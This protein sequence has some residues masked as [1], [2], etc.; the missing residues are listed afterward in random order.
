MF[1][2]SRHLLN[3]VLTLLLVNVFLFL[4]DLSIAQVRIVKGKVVDAQTHL[5]LASCSIY[6]LRSGKGV[7]SEEDGSYSLQISDRTDSIA[8]SRVGYVPVSKGVS[9]AAEQV[10]N[11]EIIPSQGGLHEVLITSKSKL[12]KAQRLIKKVIHYKDQN[13]S[14]NNKNIQSQVYDKIE[15]DVKNIPS[16]IQRNKLLKPLQFLFNNMDSSKEKN[17]FLPVYL[18]E[19]NS[20]FYYQKNPEK[21]RYDYLAIQG[22]GL[23]NSSMLTYIDGLYKK[24]NIYNNLIK[25]VD[26]NFVSPI[27]SNALA[28]YN[29]TIQDT[30]YIDDHRCIQ[31]QFSPAQYGSNTFNGF[32]WI[33]DTT[34]AIKSMV[35]HMDKKANINWVNKFQITQEFELRDQKYLPEKNILLI[36]LSIP[37]MK[38]TGIIATKTTLFRNII[39]NDLKIDTAF[40]K[41]TQDLTTLPVTNKDTTYWALHRFEPL[42]K[43]EKFVYHLMDTINKIPAIITYGKIIDALSSGYYTVGKIDIGNIFNTFSSDR[44]EGNRFDIGMKTNYH[45]NPDIQLKGYLGY[46]TRDKK[47]RYAASTLFVLNRKQWSTVKIRYM[48]DI[49]ASYDHDDE[50]DQN[51]IF[52]SL[53]RRIRSVEIRLLN[54]QE[55]NVHYNKYFNNGFAVNL[56]AKASSLTPYFNVYYTYGKFHPY[57]TADGYSSYH[58]NQVTVAI[59]YAYKEK[60]ITQHFRRGSLGSNYP[61]ITASYT[62]G[63]KVN[64]GILASDFSYDKL[65]IE[66]TQDFTDG[67]LGQLSYTISSGMTRGILPIILLDVQ[68]GNDTYYYNQYAFNNMNRFE[69][70]ADK[71]VSLFVEQ[72]F[73]S[74]PFNY[75]P[76]IKKFKWRTVANFRGVIGGMSEENKSANGYSDTSINYHFTIP[77][78]IPYM[79]AGVGIENILHVLRV[80]AVWRLSYRDNP[81]I[82]KFGI[83]GSIL[84]KF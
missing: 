60:Y 27:A 70:V 59:R 71:Y 48:N 29:Y 47:M 77:G 7:I 75:L 44:I 33:T 73:Q 56:E 6:A 13:N 83:K 15:I 25:L 32:M 41:P 79:E 20:N 57:I 58:T 81:N 66:I 26:I 80:D 52:G 2:C 30:M 63:F 54:D 11:I 78:K 18:S 61:F 16:K 23:D 3:Q 68:K 65:G 36:D 40:S 51:S 62:K 14:Y 10:I 5:P 17:K 34:Y 8:F 42:S 24:I 69:F 50:L 31:V 55:L 9:K 64:S 67:R 37:A 1:T 38:G 4:S 28:F 22:S 19:S 39:L 84:F 72:N 76:L 82:P 12:S 46:A 43:S 35:M 53:L 74:F 49:A 21:E 45:F